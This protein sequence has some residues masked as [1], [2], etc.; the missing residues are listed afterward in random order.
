MAEPKRLT[1]SELGEF[2][3]Q[4]VAG[5]IYSN[6]DLPAFESLTGES[7]GSHDDY[8]RQF[9]RVFLCFRTEPPPFDEKSVG[10]IYQRK[11]RKVSVGEGGLPV[12]MT[13]DCLHRE[14]WI[15]A[16]KLLNSDLLEQNQ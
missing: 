15:D 14:D 5:E 10:L 3:C 9:Q 13:A 8:V 7:F 4:W 12:F 6:V 16:L 1:D 2:V 11:D